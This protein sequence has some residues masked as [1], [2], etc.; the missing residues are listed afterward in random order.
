V[1]V[2][3]YFVW[4]LLDNFEWGFGYSKRFG[5]VRVDF[6]TQQ[7]TLKSSAKWYHLAIQAH[8]ADVEV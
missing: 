5:I 8:S 3:G 4:S 2:K 6:K 7:R 1:P